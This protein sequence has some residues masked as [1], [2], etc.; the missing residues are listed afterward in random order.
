MA[1]SPGIS[2]VVDDDVRDL[3]ALAARINA[4][5]PLVRA[6]A[7][8]TSIRIEG[9]QP[10]QWSGVPV[11]YGPRPRF[12]G[13]L[14]HGADGERTLHGWVIRSE[15]ARAF[16]VVGALLAGFALLTGPLVVADGDPGGFLVVAFSFVFAGASLATWVMQQRLSDAD[17]R[18]IVDS[19]STLG[20]ITSK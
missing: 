4:S 7:D 12:Q 13:G 11:Y 19:L 2:V 8:A 10:A 3:A 9:S 1:G 14:D 18:T 6:S 5:N 20:P 16:A 17:A 15:A